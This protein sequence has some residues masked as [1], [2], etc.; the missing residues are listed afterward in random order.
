MRVLMVANTLP[1]NDISGVGEQVMQLTAGLRNEGVEVEIL[2]RGVGGVLGPKVLFPLMTVVPVLRAVKRF[3]PHVV[4]LHESDGALAGLAVA[5]TRPLSDNAPQIVSLFQVSYWQELLAV[6]S[7]QTESGITAH[8]SWRER[9]FRWFK[10]PLQLLLGWLSAAVSDQVFAPSRTTAKEV[11]RD[12]RIDQVEILPNVMGREKNKFSR[13]SEVPDGEELLLFVGRLRIRKGVDILLEACKL[14]RKESIDHTLIIA[15]DGEHR[16]ALETRV[17]LLGIGSGVV[18]LGRCTASQ[19]AYLLDRARALV[20]PSFYE[21][22]PLVIL[23]AMEAGL[24]VIASRI[25]G[26]PEIVEDGVT[27]WLTEPGSIE[28]LATVLA[29]VLSNSGEAQRRGKKGRQR[30]D[31]TFRPQHTARQWLEFVARDH[32]RPE[33]HRGDYR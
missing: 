14:I 6:R 21:G 1:P 3:R 19:V 10:A 11:S 24:P 23:E 16:R 25:S 32:E 7:F 29:E 5:V 22:M 20:V 17:R 2:G 33:G 18:F 26:I 28:D 8:P 12:Y 9:W 27:G 30:L 31:S 4:Q 15:G 13:V